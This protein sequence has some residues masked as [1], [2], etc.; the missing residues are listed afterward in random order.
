MK[1]R[2]TTMNWRNGPSLISRRSPTNWP[3]FTDNLKFCSDLPTPRHTWC[4]YL[5]GT[6]W[7]S[8]NNKSKNQ[9]R[10]L[11]TKTTSSDWLTGSWLNRSK[12][13]TKRRTSSSKSPSIAGTKAPT[14]SYRIKASYWIW[15][16]E[17]LSSKASSVSFS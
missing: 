10:K 4:L 15:Q 2:T 8:R 9:K 11:I 14:R 16:K 12:R 6:T 1:P 17:L 13:R 5:L 3:E 7:V